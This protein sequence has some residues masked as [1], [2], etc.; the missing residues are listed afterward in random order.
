[1]TIIVDEPNDSA[2]SSNAPTFMTRN[3][4]VPLAKRPISPSILNQR[5][6]DEYGYGG[7]AEMMRSVCELTEIKPRRIILTKKIGFG[8][9]Q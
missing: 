4:F 2:V 5:R 9:R 8:H 6:I 1:M 7:R 3:P